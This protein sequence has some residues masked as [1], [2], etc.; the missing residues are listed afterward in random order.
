[1]AATTVLTLDQWNALLD[2]INNALTN[3][4]QTTLQHVTDPHIWTVKDITDA[5]NVLT[6][7][8]STNTFTTP[9]GPYLWEQKII[10]ELNAA[11]ANGCCGSW[12]VK[13]C[14]CSVDTNFT[15][16]HQTSYTVALGL[17]NADNIANHNPDIFYYVTQ[18]PTTTDPATQHCETCGFWWTFGWSVH[19]GRIIVKSKSLKAIGCVDSNGGFAAFLAFQADF[20]SYLS[21]L[22]GDWLPESSTAFAYTFQ[23][24]TPKTIQYVAGQNAH[25]HELTNPPLSWPVTYTT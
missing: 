6:A 12:Y 3:C 9:A 25:F 13:E 19:L 16:S 5:Q 20:L 8:C 15:L 11:I 7:A 22:G 17:A 1:M 21:G 18:S 14:I 23:C 4:P 2:A 10:D 24:N